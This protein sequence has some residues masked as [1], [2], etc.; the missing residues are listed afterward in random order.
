VPSISVSGMATTSV[1]CVPAGTTVT[2]KAST[3]KSGPAPPAD[4]VVN[5]L[6]VPPEAATEAG[7]LGTGNEERP[8]YSKIR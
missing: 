5:G 7:S 4:P 1:P 6:P 3:R 8:S 2:E